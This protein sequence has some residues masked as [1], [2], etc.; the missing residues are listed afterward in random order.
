[1]ALGTASVNRAG[2]QNVGH[3]ASALH[4]HGGVDDLILFALLRQG[5]AVTNLRTSHDLSVEQATD[6]DA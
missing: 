3:I 5:K 2:E 4:L 1:V 6:V